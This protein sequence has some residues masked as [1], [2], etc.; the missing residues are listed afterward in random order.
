MELRVVIGNFV[1]IVGKSYIKTCIYQKLFVSLQYKIKVKRTMEKSLIGR[2]YIVKDNSFAKDL[3]GKLN[4]PLLFNQNCIIIHNPYT[5]CVNGKTYLF[6]DVVVPNNEIYTKHYRVLFFEWGLLDKGEREQTKSSGLIGKIY[7]PTYN[8]DNCRMVDNKN[9]SGYLMDTDCEIISRPMVIDIVD[10]LTNKC[11]FV[12]VIIV[13][14]LETGIEYY[15]PYK[16]EWIVSYTKPNED[17][18]WNFC[19][20]CGRKLR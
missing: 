3:S 7:R 2:R 10:K 4:C 19:P 17:D 14:S 12:K 9:V 8:T 18:K 5:E 15:V 20:H 11:S 1:L 6:V 16:V 13:R